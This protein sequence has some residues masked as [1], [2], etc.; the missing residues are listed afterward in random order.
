MGERMYGRAERMSSTGAG[1]DSACAAGFVLTGRSVL[2]GFPGPR[3][4]LSDLMDTRM[5]R[6]AV[7]EPSTAGSSSR[8]LGA[9]QLGPLS[10]LVLSAWCGLVSGLL[11][12]GVVGVAETDFIG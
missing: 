9:N 10:V 12:V 8:D 6:T 5:S 4:S 1:R 2:P 7:F 11:E 3:S